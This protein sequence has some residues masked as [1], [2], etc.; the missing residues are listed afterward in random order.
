MPASVGGGRYRLFGGG[1]AEAEPTAVPAV[2]RLSRTARRLAIQNLAV[3][4][5]FLTGLVIWD[6]VGTPPSPSAPPDTR[7][8]PLSSGSTACAAAV[9]A[10]TDR[11]AAAAPART[12][13]SH[14]TAGY[15]VHP[16]ETE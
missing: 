8:P 15:P 6:L 13:S 2:L 16:K 11:P 4:A 10:R 9:T 7:A 1:V 12:N 14:I 5:V 3:A